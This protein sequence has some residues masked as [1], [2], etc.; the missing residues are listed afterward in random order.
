[1]AKRAAVR[2]RKREREGERERVDADVLLAGHTWSVEHWLLYQYP[3]EKGR[4]G[5]CELGQTNV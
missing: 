3:L 1:M 2:E 4:L 5:G